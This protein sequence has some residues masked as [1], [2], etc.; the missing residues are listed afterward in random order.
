MASVAE[1]FDARR[2][3]LTMFIEGQLRDTRLLKDFIELRVD[4]PNMTE[5]SKGYWYIFTEI[6]VLVQSAQDQDNYHRIYASVGI[7]AAAFEQIIRISRLGSGVDDDQSLVG[8]IKLQGDKDARE[9][10]QI[11][12]FGQVEPRTGIFQSTVE[13]HYA[14]NLHE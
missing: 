8:C 9:R 2:Q 11:S 4:G 10:I 1:H 5:L 6:N 13:G 12:H 3:G 14:M 7:V